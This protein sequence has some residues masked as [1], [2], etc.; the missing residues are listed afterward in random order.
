MIR[1]DMDQTTITSCVLLAGAEYDLKR[2]AEEAL[3]LSYQPQP[4]IRLDSLHALG[5]MALEKLEK[6]DC[7]IAR[8][9]KRFDEVIESPIS[10]KDA[11]TAIRAALGLLDRLGGG[12][13][14]MVKPLLEKACKN[15]TS[16]MRCEIS[17]N[18]LYCQKHYTEE[19]KDIS[20]SAIQFADKNEPNTIGE[21]DLILEQ[22]N[23][24]D[25]RERKRVLGFLKNLLSHGETAIEIKELRSFQR[26]LTRESGTMLGWYVVSFLLTGEP[27]LCTAANQLLP[28]NHVSKG[29]DI[30]LAPFTLD[31]RWV[32]FLARKVLGYCLFN[33]ASA[34]TLL[35]SCLRDMSQEGKIDE[36][37]NLILEYFLINYPR[38]I[39]QFEALVSPNDLA[40]ESVK[41]LSIELKKYLD[42]LR[43]GG[44][45]DAFR[46]SELERHL[47]SY[48]RTN[49]LRN[50][51]KKAEESSI[52]FPFGSKMT[53]LYGTHFVVHTYT[54]ASSTPLRQEVPLTSYEHVIEF[55]RLKAIDP[56][57]WQYAIYH[58]QSEPPPP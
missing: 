37:E 51:M 23:L 13:V 19:M 58:F 15:P 5:L 34:A 32:L 44:I 36:L 21:I 14:D 55:P 20:L 27:R 11:I 12:F 43:Q 57:G 26:K 33:S 8:A 1:N 46:P 6:D 56:V 41:R 45:C 22:W 53:M 16:N 30:D 24:D 35:M 2:F 3:E 49:L 39:D 47:Q 17:S 38:A 10:D 29:L 31:H 48:H 7:I 25:D 18:L 54:D 40:Q 28:Y 50:E 9:I 4:R 42:G 52:F